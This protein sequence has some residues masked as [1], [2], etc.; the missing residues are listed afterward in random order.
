MNFGKYAV[1]DNT[2]HNFEKEPDLFWKF[3]PAYSGDELAMVRFYEER[4]K[5]VD[6]PEGKKITVGPHWIEVMWHE[7]GLLFVDTNLTD[8][9]GEPVLQPFA[10]PEEVKKVLAKMPEGMVEEIWIA[11]GKAVPGWGPRIAQPES[12]AGETNSES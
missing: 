9:K 12:E 2:T 1:L 10:S 11:M 8:E 3:H 7:I 5:L 6:G 4:T